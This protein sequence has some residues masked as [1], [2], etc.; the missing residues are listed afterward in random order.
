[1]KIN[2]LMETENVLL[3]YLLPADVEK[4]FQMSRE[5][6]MQQWIPDQVYADEKESAEV[7]A[8]LSTQYKVPPHPHEAP[9][10]LGVELKS[11]QELIGHAG[12][13]PAG[14]S[15]E[16]GYAIEEKHQGKGYATEAVRAL[17]DWA[18]KMLQIPEVLGIVDRDNKRSCSVLEKSGFTLIEE[19]EK[20]AFGRRSVCRIYRK[21]AWGRDR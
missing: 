10:V 20:D 1:M 12:L 13:S 18:V 3:R 15:V 9:F 17:S 11:T 16:I 2:L 19:N 7:I 14:G 5:A 21:T 6:G 8:F 4:I